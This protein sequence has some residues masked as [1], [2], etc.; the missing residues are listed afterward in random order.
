MTDDSGDI[1]LIARDARGFRAGDLFGQRPFDFTRSSTGEIEVIFVMRAPIRYAP[2]IVDGIAY[3]GADDGMVRARKYVRRCRGLVS[4]HVGPAMPAIIGNNRLIS[5]HP[6]RTS[7]LAGAQFVYASGWSVSYS[8]CLLGALDRATGKV[9]WRRNTTKSPQGYL[10]SA[11]DNLLYVP[12]G[13][14]LPFAIRRMWSSRR[15]FPSPGE[16]FAC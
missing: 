7:V 14:A 11:D 8:E 12:T 5:P 3:L 2:S 1:P 13:R 4:V 16:T 6:V 10:L 15:N 9:H